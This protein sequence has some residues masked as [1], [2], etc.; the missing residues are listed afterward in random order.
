MA[1]PRTDG[2]GVGIVRNLSAVHVQISNR[3]L[4][5]TGNFPYVSFLSLMYVPLA[6]PVVVCMHRMLH[7]L[8]SGLRT[9]TLGAPPDLRGG[10][11]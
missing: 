3:D 6:P 5:A 7:P 2:H 8:S 10:P 4:A 9:I 11:L 1:V